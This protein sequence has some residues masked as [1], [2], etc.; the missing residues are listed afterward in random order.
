MQTVIE[1]KQALKQAEANAA[2]ERKA[3]AGRQLEA[4]RATGRKLKRELD[5]IVKAVQR[6]DLEVLACDGEIASYNNAIAAHIASKPDP[7]DFPSQRQFDAWES[8]L[9]RLASERD[10]AVVRKRAV[11]GGDRL[12]AI[13]LDAEITR[14][15][16]VQENLSRIVRGELVAD[17]EQGGGGLRFV[18]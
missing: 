13:A 10:K 11:Q 5:G 8:E 3:E 4:V 15:R 7:V 18:S 2:R 6:H 14:L 12:R 16:Y 1:A 17:V 9:K